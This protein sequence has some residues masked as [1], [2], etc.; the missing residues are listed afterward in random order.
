M[1]AERLDSLIRAVQE[2]V[3]ARAITFL[4]TDIATNGG[5]VILTAGVPSTTGNDEEEMLLA[6]RRVISGGPALPIS[7]GVTWGRVFAGE[8]GTPYRRTYT[9][10]GDT[11]NLAARLMARAPAGEMYASAEV[12]SGSR[13]TF[14]LSSLEPFMVKGKKLPI[15]AL[16]VGDPQGSKSQAG[17][18][19]APTHR[20]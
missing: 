17:S 6:L 20:A 12:I 4:A 2:A 7:V 9:V 13:T 19:W 11:V 1:A 5:K 10:M 3:D 16:S 18:R 14:D 15:N 8:V